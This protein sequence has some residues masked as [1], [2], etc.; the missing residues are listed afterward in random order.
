VDDWAAVSRAINQRMDELDLNQ[1]ELIER[2]QVSRATVGEIRRNE[3]QRRRSTRTLEALS[4]ALDWHP[5]H[6][7]AVLQGRSAPKLGEPVA[8][9]DD[10]LPGRLA[11]IE[12]VLQQI[13][14]K[15]EDIDTLSE[16]I[17]EI[18]AK[19]DSAIDAAAASRERVEH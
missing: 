11:A 5:Q 9:S 4:I 3:A 1:R 12:Y 7:S 17:D 16:R 6:L 13:V 10:D 19:V 14:K 8:R 2:S 15:L 18:N